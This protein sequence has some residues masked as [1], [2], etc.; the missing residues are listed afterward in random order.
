MRKAKTKTALEIIRPGHADPGGTGGGADIAVI[1]PDESAEGLL[2][3]LVKLVR[4]DVDRLIL[5]VAAKDR[6]LC[7][8]EARVVAGYLRTLSDHVKSTRPKGGGEDMEE[9][10][11][12]EEALKHPRLREAL[13]AS[14][15]RDKTFGEADHDQ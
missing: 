12:M 8:D 13:L 15:Q 3:D 5:D 11:L 10:E 9:K 4:A 1:G 14:M 6:L 7:P 2:G